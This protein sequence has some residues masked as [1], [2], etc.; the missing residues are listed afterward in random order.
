MWS[1]LYSLDSNSCGRNNGSVFIKGSNILRNT[2]IINTRDHFEILMSVS[3]VSNSKRAEMVMVTN[4]L[5]IQLYMG[6]IMEV[7]TWL[8]Y[9]YLP[10]GH[11]S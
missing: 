9:C 10:A 5:H 8:Y 1:Q 4:L 11:Q 7:I 6:F 3:I 2:L